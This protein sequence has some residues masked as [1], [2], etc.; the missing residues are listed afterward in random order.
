M[1]DLADLDAT[2]TAEAIRDEEISPSEAVAAAIARIEK[3]NPDLNAVVHPMFDKA[4]DAAASP[5]LPYGPFRGVPIVMKDLNT[6]TAG[7]P[8]H[9][10]MRF[11][12]DLRWTA[13]EDG[14]IASRLR[15]AGFVIVGRT[16]TP[17]LG[18]L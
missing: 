9:E 8:Y 16:N 12:R 7:H 13:D 17:E 15:A 5:E 2:G 4:T 18:L 3:L 11:L 6:P 14:T 10:G 1:T